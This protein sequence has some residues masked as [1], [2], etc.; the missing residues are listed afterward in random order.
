MQDAKIKEELLEC[1]NPT[2]KSKSPFLT[3]LEKITTKQKKQ[4]VT[5]LNDDAY[6]RDEHKKKIKAEILR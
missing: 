1:T 6:R 3:N 4:C 5:R 2:N